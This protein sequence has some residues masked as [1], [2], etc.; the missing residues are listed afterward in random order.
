MNNLPLQILCVFVGG[1]VGS[2]LRFFISFIL[3]NRF[4]HIQYLGTILVNLGGCFIIGIITGLTL[5]INMS[6]QVRVM[7]VSGFLG[8]LTTFSTFSLESLQ[9]VYG[10]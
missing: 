8:G 5:K 7:I 10:Q 4:S 1:G 2:I 6:G 3:N 9:R